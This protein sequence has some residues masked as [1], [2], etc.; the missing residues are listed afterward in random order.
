MAAPSSSLSADTHGDEVKQPAVQ[1]SPSDS[2]VF[3]NDMSRLRASDT[4]VVLS[5]ATAVSDSAAAADGASV[6][7]SVSGGG[8][9]GGDP[10][11]PLSDEWAAGSSS[12]SSSLASDDP[13]G[14]SSAD[15]AYELTSSPNAFASF[16]KPGHVDDHQPAQADSSRRKSK[17]KKNKAALQP[18][19]S[20]AAAVPA[21]GPTPDASVAAVSDG[22]DGPQLLM[23]DSLEY[24]AMLEQR[25]ERLKKKQEA[26]I[27]AASAKT[28]RRSSQPTHRPPKTACP[29]STALGHLTPAQHSFSG[30]LLRT[31]LRVACVCACVRTCVF[32]CVCVCVCV[33]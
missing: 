10:F 31:V 4:S 2:V 7:V 9:G 13:F 6:S 17:K 22:A 23:A 12:S 30:S 32:V 14:S 24:V 15:G 26:R 21:A 1:P 3:V 33:S 5:P 27:K 29:A 25:L 20:E 19:S 16:P 28:T 11:G 18:S 8:G